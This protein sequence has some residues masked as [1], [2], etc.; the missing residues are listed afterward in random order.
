MVCITAVD[1]GLYHEQLPRDTAFQ[2]VRGK[3]YGEVVCVFVEGVA[4][5]PQVFTD[6]GVRN[7]LTIPWRAIEEVARW[8]R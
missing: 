8:Q 4:L 3:L 7:V 5:A 1:W 6:G 2:I